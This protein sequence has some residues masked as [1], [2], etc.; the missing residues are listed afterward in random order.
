[1]EYWHSRIQSSGSQAQS[2][3]LTEFVPQMN[4]G[5]H[6]IRELLDFLVL[7]TSIGARGFFFLL[8]PSTCVL[9]YDIPEHACPCAAT[10]LVHM[11]Y[12]HILVLYFVTQIPVTADKIVYL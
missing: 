11:F 3:V 4:Q 12:L 1:M 6:R 10:I 5:P 9:V 2:D 7:K 8:N